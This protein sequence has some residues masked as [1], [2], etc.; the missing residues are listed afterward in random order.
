MDGLWDS[1]RT[2]SS[3]AEGLTVAINLSDDGSRV[4]ASVLGD[5]DGA[6]E[7]GFTLSS[8]PFTAA[9]RVLRRLT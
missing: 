1:D 8:S 2:P 5:G 3:G 9:G 6:V 7:N 4:L